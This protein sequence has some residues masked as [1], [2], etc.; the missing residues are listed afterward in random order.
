MMRVSQSANRLP[1]ATEIRPPTIAPQFSDSGRP[2]AST[3]TQTT[4]MLR[5]TAAGMARGRAR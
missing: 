3:S 1:K 4:A 5:A 2:D